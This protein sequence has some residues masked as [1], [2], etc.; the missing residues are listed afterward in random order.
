MFGL[1]KQRG[2]TLIELLI[3]MFI[4][5]CLTVGVGFAIWFFG[6]V[7]FHCW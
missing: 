6:H 1:R 3:V 5:L 4:L 2:F 7:V